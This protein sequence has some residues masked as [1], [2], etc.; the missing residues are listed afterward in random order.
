MLKRDDIRLGMVLGFIAPLLGVVLYYFIAFAGLHVSFSEFIGY[1]CRSKRI[2]TGV[3][4]ISL[5]ANAVLFTFYVNARKD[6]TIKGIFLVTVV[7]GIA[8]LLIKLLA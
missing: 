7:Y 1:L 3:S 4:S 8:V 5:I 6:K 2:L